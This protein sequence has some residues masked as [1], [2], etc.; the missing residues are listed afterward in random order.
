MANDEASLLFLAN[1]G[2]IEMHALHGRCPRPAYPD[3]VFF[4][5]DPFEPATVDDA[6]DVAEYLHAALRALGLPSYPR[7]SGGTGVH[8]YVPIEPGPSF[9]STRL[10]ADRIAHAVHDV[11]V[12]QTTLE[13]AVAKRAG[14]VFIDVNMNRR[15]QNVASAWSAR[16]TI[17][18]TV[19]V[20]LSWDELRRHPKPSDFTIENAHERDD[21]GVMRA[22]ADVRAPMEKMGVRPELVDPDEHR[23]TPHRGR[24]QQRR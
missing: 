16:P 13:W 3:Y 2:C 18:A 10:F 23:A 21:D 8:V 1:L 24:L 6:M 5:L 11:A 7:L 4:D 9:D 22:P 14:K 20:P 17:D 12:E 19:C 15:G